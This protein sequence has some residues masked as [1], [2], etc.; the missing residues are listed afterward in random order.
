MPTFNFVDLIIAAIIAA[1][2]VRGVRAG[3]WPLAARLI[4]LVVGL[5]GAL[6]LYPLIAP[7]IASII[8]IHIQLVY[9]GSFIA[10]FIIVQA[11]AHALISHLFSYIPEE[12]RLSP[13]SKAL[14]VF[15]AFV[16][17]T[18]LVSLLVLVAVVFPVPPAVREVVTNSYIGNYIVNVLPRTERIAQQWFGGAVERGL[19]YLT[20]KPDS[21]ESVE[22]PYR[23]A[24]LVIDEG[25]EARML[26]LVNRERA[27]VGAPP[28]VIDQ[29]LVA[30]AREHSTDMWERGYFAHTNPDGLDPFDRM[31]AGGATFLIAGENLAFAPTVGLAH[32]GLMNSE[33]H[34]RNILD[35]RFGR[36][37][38]GV[39]DGG[40]YGKMYTQNFAN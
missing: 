16:D 14:G 8:E 24:E 11:L 1:H 38:I 18:I 4:A 6:W 26:E 28:L 21:D 39:I 10:V 23:P 29:T 25:G 35:P 7:F 37:G 19:T 22:I 5:V 12:W 2:L 9:I 33:G 32:W 34:K 31:E 36:I 13:V 30:V 20:T 17:G 27:K 40:I 15:P 3:F